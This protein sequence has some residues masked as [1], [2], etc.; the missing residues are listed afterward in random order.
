MNTINIP[1]GTSN[2]AEIRRKGSYFIDKSSLIEQ[3]LKTQSTKVTLITRPR[4]FGKTLG[5][6]MLSEFFDIQKNSRALF[7]GLSVMK[8]KGLCRQWMNQ[9]PT[10]FLS[11]RSVDGLNF[12]GA[13]AQLASVIAE[14]Y[15]KHIYL[16]ESEGIQPLDKEQFHRTAAEKADLKGIKNSLLKLTQLMELHY[17]KPVILIIDEYDV[18]LAKAS[19]KG[20]YREMQDAIKGVMQVIKD[21]NSL[22][23]AVI[24]GCLQIAKESIF[25]GTNNFV[26]D[27]ISDTQLNESFGFTQDEVNRLLAD[28]GLAP[29]A[30]EI[31]E[32]YDGYHFGDFDVY[33]PWDVMNHVQNLLLNPDSKPKNFWENTSDNSIIRT[34]L[35]RTDFDINDKFE[36]LLAGEYIVEPIEENLT[37]DVLESSEENLWSLLYLT[38]Y[39]TRLRPDEI[40]GLRLLPGHYALKVPNKE[41]LGIFK[42]S[43]KAWLME[44]T[45]QKDRNELFAAL[46]DENAQRLTELISDLLFD[47]I[48]YHDY[49]E[50]F[51]HAFLTGLF[52]NAGYRVESNYENGLGRSDL[53]VKDRR[54]RR[55]VVLEAKR[56]YYEDQME[57]A[58]EEALS[59]IREKQYAEKVER[60]GYKKAGRLGIAFFQKKCLV[61]KG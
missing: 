10:L 8:N 47:T 34:F 44:T 51:Y 13:Y 11:F 37:Y 24:T 22:E 27:T 30:E 60:D 16:T 48:S 25:T 6:S 59:Q 43:V 41:V 53:V 14:L 45:A 52:S 61:K 26:S 40:P 35:K 39:L 31:R 21:N 1:V 12:S 23:F 57:N 9:Y 54:N 56:T 4:R 15:K 5:M 33:C 2:F 58:C 55:A 38:G 19:E 28:T 49:A 18:P 3:L 50:S 32:W 46:W 7:E 29:Y 17:Q 36:T 20:Y 42:K